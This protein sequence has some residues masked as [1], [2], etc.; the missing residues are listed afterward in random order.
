MRDVDARNGLLPDLLAVPGGPCASQDGLFSIPCVICGERLLSQCLSHSF[1]LK[2]VIL[3][4]T[5]GILGS[6]R[7]L[8]LPVAAHAEQRRLEA[9]RSPDICM[10]FKNWAP[11]LF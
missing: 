2:Q 9:R 5:G 3:W 7:G 8:R 11:I 1:R 4:L 6:R 10:F